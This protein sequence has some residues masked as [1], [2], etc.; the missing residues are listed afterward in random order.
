[1][2][3][4]YWRLGDTA[5]APYIHVAA[6]MLLCY[7]IRTSRM[8]PHAP[9]RQELAISASTS[10]RDR[11]GSAHSG[12]AAHVGQGKGGPPPLLGAAESGSPKE[13]RLRWPS[14]GGSGGPLRPSLDPSPALR[15]GV[16][17]IPLPTSPAATTPD[18]SYTEG[19][20][21]A[22]KGP[23]VPLPARP[24]GASPPPRS[25]NTQPRPMDLRHT[26][27][28]GTSAQRRPPC[29]EMPAPARVP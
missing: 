9:R 18:L 15:G 7:T 6:G 26:R 11:T 23:C 19:P 10:Y 20:L 14:P 17:S 4:A 28:P 5:G 8:E 21:L 24:P 12:P 16:G 25:R 22:L 27:P 13:E 3:C 2:G 1:M 29:P